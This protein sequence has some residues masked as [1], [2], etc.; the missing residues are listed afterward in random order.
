MHN[1]EKR[2]SIDRGERLMKREYYKLTRTILFLWLTT[3]NVGGVGLINNKQSKKRE[4][5]VNVFCK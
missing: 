4:G 5:F 2:C 1:T 3:V